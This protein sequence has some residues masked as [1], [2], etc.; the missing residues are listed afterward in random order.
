MSATP[1]LGSR[2]RFSTR[3]GGERPDCDYLIKTILLGDLDV[4]K[5]TFMHTYLHGR[6]PAAGAVPKLGAANGH[7][8]VVYHGKRVKLTMWDTAGQERYRSLT[9]SYYRGAHAC[10]VMYDVSSKESFDSVTSWMES[11]QDYNDANSGTVT[12]L[13]GV[14]KTRESSQRAHHV[15]EVDQQRAVNLS[16]HYQIPHF[17]VDCLNDPSSVD[18]VMNTMVTMVMTKAMENSNLSQ[19]IRPYSTK[20]EMISHKGQ[21]RCSG[22]CNL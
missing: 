2:P 8:T 5:T 21:G 13:V 1:V 15:T 17:T 7:K 18:F 3:S 10:L 22:C 19:T 9:A 14:R 12:M 6:C 4:G 20:L 16:S 11:V